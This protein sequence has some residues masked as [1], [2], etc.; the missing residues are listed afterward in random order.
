M[1]TIIAPVFGPGIIIEKRFPVDEII[2][3]I[4]RIVRQVLNNS[5][6]R[7][8]LSVLKTDR[9][10]DSRLRTTKKIHGHLPGNGNAHRSG[11]SRS[12]LSFKNRITEHPEKISPGAAPLLLKDLLPHLESISIPPGKTSSHLHLRQHFF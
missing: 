10:I 11:K 3:L 9:L 7:K 4:R 6:D 12:C 2:E 5:R 8:I 1:R